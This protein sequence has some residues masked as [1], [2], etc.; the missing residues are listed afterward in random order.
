VD[1]EGFNSLRPALLRDSLM[2]RI[3][4]RQR[5]FVSGQNRAAGEILPVSKSTPKRH[6]WRRNS[7]SASVSRILCLKGEAKLP[8]FLFRNYRFATCPSDRGQPFTFT[9]G[10]GWVELLGIN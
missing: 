8:L 2:R 10:A 7:L 5:S 3:G 4:R 1:Y 6:L 9:L